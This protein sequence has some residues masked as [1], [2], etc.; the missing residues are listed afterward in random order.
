[1]IPVSHLFS[2][3]DVK[4]K[5]R[6]KDKQFKTDKGQTSANMVHRSQSHGS[7]KEKGQR[8]KPKRTTTFVRKMD[9]DS[10]D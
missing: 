7:R 6:A 9:T 4:E 3:F 10:F 1:M 5:A 8:T 2:S